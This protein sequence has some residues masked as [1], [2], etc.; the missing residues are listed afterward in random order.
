MQLGDNRARLCFDSC[1][2]R[3]Y[4]AFVGLHRVLAAGYLEYSELR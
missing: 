2:E 4:D 3:V 1:Q